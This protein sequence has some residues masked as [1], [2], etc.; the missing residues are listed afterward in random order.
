MGLA[1]VDDGIGMTPEVGER[2][3]EL[4][5]QAERASDRRKAD[6][7]RPVAGSQ[8]VEPHGGTVQGRSERPANLT[9]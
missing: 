8:P 1:V 6:W 2:V 7:T 5:T 9:A 4:F 3:F